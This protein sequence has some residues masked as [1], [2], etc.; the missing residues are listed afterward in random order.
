MYRVRRNR[1][2][3][4]LFSYGSNNLEQLE[5]RLGHPVT[6]NSAYVEGMG[7][8]FRGNSRR[9]G[10]GVATLIPLRSATTYGYVAEVSE[11]DLDTLDQYE[12]VPTN[13]RREQVQV[14]ME[15]SG[16]FVPVLATVYLSNSTVKTPPS[17]AYLQAIAQL[18]NDFWRE[19]GRKITVSD[20]T[21]R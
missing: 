13:Y 17:R 3:T 14:M 12:G 7:R 1:R 5:E 8:A 2:K 19:D 6:G 20:I 10:G 15:K 16:D 11:D 18:L 21:I 4:Y 9:W